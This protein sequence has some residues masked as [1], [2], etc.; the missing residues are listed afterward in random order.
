MHAPNPKNIG[1]ALGEIVADNDTIN[2]VVG[3]KG[4][5]WYPLYR[6]LKTDC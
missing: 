3:R 6:L 4:K 1:H 2:L 5:L